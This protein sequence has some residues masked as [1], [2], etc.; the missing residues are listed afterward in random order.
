[1]HGAHSVKKV[2]QLWCN[3]RIKIDVLESIIGRCVCIIWGGHRV[4]YNILA[5][6]AGRPDPR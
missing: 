3:V 6:C 4:V 1:M 5:P 2:G